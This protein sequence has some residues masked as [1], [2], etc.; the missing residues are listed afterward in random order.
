MRQKVRSITHDSTL[1]ARAPATKELHAPTDAEIQAALSV[2]RDLKKAKQDRHVEMEKR[3]AAERELDSV[4]AENKALRASLNESV[5]D[6]AVLADT[7]APE[8]AESMR[9]AIGASESPDLAREAA[10][11]IR[12]FCEMVKELVS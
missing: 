7:L 4:K 6:L 3:K 5:E 2:L 10:A 11:Y 12:E 8:R 9:F 1:T